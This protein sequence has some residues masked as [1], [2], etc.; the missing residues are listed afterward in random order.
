LIVEALDIHGNRP[1]EALTSPM[2]RPQD[3]FDEP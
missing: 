3:L 1:P 2:N